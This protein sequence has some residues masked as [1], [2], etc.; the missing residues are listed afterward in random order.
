MGGDHRSI[1]IRCH[2]D[3]PMSIPHYPSHLLLLLSTA[4]MPKA[5]GSKATLSSA[6]TNI[7]KKPA[8]DVWQRV[9]HLSNVLLAYSVYK[10]SGVDLDD[11]RVALKYDTTSEILSC[12]VCYRTFKVE[13]KAATIARV[14]YSHLSSVLHILHVSMVF[15]I[16]E[17]KIEEHFPFQCG[18]CKKYYSYITQVLSLLKSAYPGSIFTSRVSRRIQPYVAKDKSYNEYK[19][20]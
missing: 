4:I 11:P 14:V 1:K 19:A 20:A 7:E 12:P 9:R 15:G 5:S 2:G 18:A 3:L 17:S 8:P 6:M 13:P 10:A 16:P